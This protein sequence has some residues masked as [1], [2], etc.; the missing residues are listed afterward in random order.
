M[1]NLVYLIGR[2]VKNVDIENNEKDKILKIAVPRSYKNDNGVYEIDLFDVSVIGGIAQSVSEYCKTGDMIGIRGRVE[3]KE[4]EEQKQTFIVA[5]KIS[6]LTS[7]AKS[8]DE[9]EMTK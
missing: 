1:N 9:K 2:I 4:K 5:E 7:K 8:S 3:T 6:F